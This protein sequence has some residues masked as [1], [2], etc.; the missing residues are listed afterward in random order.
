MTRLDKFWSNQEVL[1]DYNTICM[2]SEIV[3]GYYS[4]VFY[5]KNAGLKTNLLI[6]GRP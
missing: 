1:F 3:V 4:V 5:Y 2:A 6:F